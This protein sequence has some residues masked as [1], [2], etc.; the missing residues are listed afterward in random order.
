MMDKVKFKK[1]LFGAGAASL[2]SL[3]A[4]GVNFLSNIMIARFYGEITYADF[5]FLFSL[6]TVISLLVTLG[7]GQLLL[8]K[9]PLLDHNSCRTLVGGI[10]AFILVVTILISPI[11]SLYL[12]NMGYSCF[13]VGCFVGS[14]VLLSTSHIRQSIYFSSERVIHFQLWDKLF[15]VLIFCFFI[16]V[17]S[18]YGASNLDYL[19]FALLLGSFLSG[20]FLVLDRKMLSLGLLKFY[21]SFSLSDL[22]ISIQLYSVLL[23]TTLLTN[24]DILILKNIGNGAELAYFSAAQKL[25]LVGNIF[26]ISITNIVTPLLVKAEDAQDNNFNLYTKYTTIIG[27]LSLLAFWAISCIFGKYALSLFGESFSEGFSTLV[28]LVFSHLLSAS[29][30]QTLTVMKIK[31]EMRAILVY[32]LIAMFLKAIT[33]Y[34]LYI[35]LG[36]VGVAL[37]SVLV[38]GSWNILCYLHLKSKYKINTTMLG[39]LKL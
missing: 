21:G 3:L 32:M 11:L 10:N 31:K 5:S 34:Y 7:A 38:V 12:L 26:L 4:S 1:I 13:M 24:I 36:I 17:F 23:I 29:F 20:L 6:L 22:K 30:G 33:I 37:S 39:V 16:Y 8:M 25:S 19:M 27:F 35:N 9:L 18:L 15:K 2:I 14:F 28:I